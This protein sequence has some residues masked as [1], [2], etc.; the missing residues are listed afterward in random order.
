M[1]APRHYRALPP[2]MQAILLMVLAM[3]CFATMNILVRHVSGG[4]PTALIVFFRNVFA[5][6][7]L[8]PWIARKGIRVIKTKNIFGHFW[9]GIFGVISMEL[10]F[11]SLAVMPVNQ[12]TALSFTTPIFVTVIALLF[13]KE[14][15]GIHRW[16]AIIAGFAGVLIILRPEVNGLDRNALAVLTSSVFM[17]GASILVKTLTRTEKPGVIVFY[18]AFFLMVFSAPL[19]IAHWQ[20]LTLAEYAAIAAIAAFSTLAHLCLIRAYPK[21]EM[22]TL[23]PFDFT[24]LIFTAA[25]AYCMFGEVIEG[26][27]LLGAL[28]IVLSA[29]FIARREA[30]QSGKPAFDADV[31]SG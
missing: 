24:R 7:L 23:M 10:W 14:T 21:A 12:A 11:Y 8:L 18:M 25:L 19:A 15:A 1:I 31:V 6:G 9:R 4:A 30:R 17:A 22:A 26:R 29:A 28:I 27:T 16:S 3:F 2:T 5:L 13:L 20:T